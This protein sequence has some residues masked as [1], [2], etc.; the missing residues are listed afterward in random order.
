M[1]RREKMF[2][3][4]VFLLT[5]LSIITCISDAYAQAPEA[6]LIRITRG[7]PNAKYVQDGRRDQRPVEAI[8]GQR[9][10]VVNEDVDQDHTVTSIKTD[11]Q[12][13]P[14]FDTGF[15]SSRSSSEITITPE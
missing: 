5:A 4:L 2:G 13:K 11:G 15:I 3:F 9:I 8:V 14:L 6:I 1:S 12:K 7:G 10:R